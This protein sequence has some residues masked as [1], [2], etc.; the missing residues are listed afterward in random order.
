MCNPTPETDKNN[1]RSSPDVGN[2]S[3]CC[4]SATLH[5]SIY[6]FLAVHKP[7]KTYCISWAVLVTEICVM[8]INGYVL[9]NF[10]YT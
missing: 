9:K 2:I 1:T 4:A 3:M 8:G 6:R 5:D 7:A 10:N